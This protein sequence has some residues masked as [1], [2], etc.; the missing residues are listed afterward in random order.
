MA[1]AALLLVVVVGGAA[2]FLSGTT[3]DAPSSVAVVASDGNDVI[4]DAF[5]AQ[6]SGLQLASGQ[7][8]LVAHN[9]DL[10]P[11]I[12]ALAVGDTVAFYGVYEWNAEGGV[13][14]WTHRDPDGVH[15]AGWLQHEG[16]VYQ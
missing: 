16:A 2:A 10:A 3:P 11:R 7:T 1:A 4:S 14:H 13:I 15:E 8:L 9:I 5:N 6:R 12:P